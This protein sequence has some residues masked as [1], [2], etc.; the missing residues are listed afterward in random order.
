[1]RDLQSLSQSH[2]HSRCDSIHGFLVFPSCF[3]L[4]CFCSGAGH[5]AYRKV[6]VIQIPI[7]RRD[8]GVGVNGVWLFRE[9]PGCPSVAGDKTVAG[10]RDP[11]AFVNSPHAPLVPSTCRLLDQ[12]TGH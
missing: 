11:A 10:R 6:G 2:S 7:V 5:A 9:L 1:M 12:S 4:I 8:T 3:V